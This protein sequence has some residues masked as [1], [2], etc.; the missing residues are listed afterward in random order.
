M[1]EWTARCVE[2]GK[3]FVTVSINI[4]CC[5]PEHTERWLARLAA[6]GPMTPWME[7]VHR[8]IRER[9]RRLAEPER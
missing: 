7:D 5:C 3:P 1:D 9:A 8:Q 2:C 4:K 6:L